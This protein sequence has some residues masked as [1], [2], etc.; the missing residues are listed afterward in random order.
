MRKKYYRCFQELI[1]KS[2]KVYYDELYL[3]PVS[4]YFDTESEAR[5]DF[6]IAKEMAEKK[7]EKIIREIDRLKKRIGFEISFNVEGDTHGIF[8]EYQYIT[9]TVKGYRFTA[10]L[11]D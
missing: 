1:G 7:S 3:K 6:K 2:V 10:I 9:F 4:G 11:P 8:N 5:E